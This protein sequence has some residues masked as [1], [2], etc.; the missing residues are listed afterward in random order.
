MS[1]RCW[2]V[3]CAALCAGAL[4]GCIVYKSPA[5]KLTACAGELCEVMADAGA[6]GAPWSALVERFDKLVSRQMTVDLGTGTP[7]GVLA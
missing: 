4:S 1:R 5:V 3:S 2:V 6:D 7:A